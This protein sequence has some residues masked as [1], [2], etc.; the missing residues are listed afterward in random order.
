MSIIFVKIL[1]MLSVS[2]I[3]QGPHIGNTCYTFENK[4]TCLHIQ[5]C[6]CF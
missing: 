2:V 6:T 3:A 1:G 5:V 4:S